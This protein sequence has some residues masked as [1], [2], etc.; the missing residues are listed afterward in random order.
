M[1]SRQKQQ[2]DDGDSS[3]WVAVSQGP[4]GSPGSPG[5]PGPSTAV[6]AP[7]E[8]NWHVPL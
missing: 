5:T 7:F 6:A 4:A 8:S 2:Y 1:I 3:Q